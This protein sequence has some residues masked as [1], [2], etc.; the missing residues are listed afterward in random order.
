MKLVGV[1][2]GRLLVK[3]ARETV[4]NS[5]KSGR[6]DVKKIASKTLE[7]KY[8]AF[9][10]IHSYPGR[11]LRGCIGFLSPGR[12]YEVIQQAAYAA[13]FQDPRFPPLEKDDLGK[14]IFE[15]S[16]MTQ[17]EC[18]KWMPKDYA[19]NI[20]IGEDGLIMQYE[21]T[22]GLLLPQVPVEEKWNAEEFLEN[23][24][25]KTG[26]TPDYLNDKSTTI[27][28]FHAQIF[29]EKAPNGEVEETEI[30]R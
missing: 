28:K 20:E 27:W 23:L 21:G 25:F 5:L 9:V 11:R 30:S 6:L 29:S 15:I 22:S 13:A 19:K 7:A 24:C 26:L 1:G 3:L 18:M 16:I 2:D 12:L 8:G 4:E 17:P 10:T 14:V